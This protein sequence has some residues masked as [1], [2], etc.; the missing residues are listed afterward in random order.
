ML[1]NRTRQLINLSLQGFYVLL[2]LFQVRIILEGLTEF[3]LG[4]YERTAKFLER[5]A[6]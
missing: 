3:T 1:I 5:S 2:A 4:S 6:G